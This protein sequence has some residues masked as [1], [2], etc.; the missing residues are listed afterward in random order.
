MIV[1]YYHAYLT[2]NYQQIIAYHLDKLLDSELAQNLDQPLKLGLV[3]PAAARQQIATYCSERIPTKVVAEAD[4]GWEQVTL[5]VLHADAT[6]LAP[7][8]SVLYAHTKGVSSTQSC[9]QWRENI[10]RGVVTNWRECVNKLCE[11]EA[12][13]CYWLPETVGPFFAGNFWWAKASLLQRMTAPNNGERM[14]AEYW[15]NTAHPDVYDIAVGWPL[16]FYDGQPPTQRKIS[17]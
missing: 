11:H 16:A 15:M 2:G 14:W 17:F 1:H 3:G 6:N 5:N 8:D 7:T 9:D 4:K 12:V 10:T 13:G